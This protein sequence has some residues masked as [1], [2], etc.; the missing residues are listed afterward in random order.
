MIQYTCYPCP[1]GIIKIGWENDRV[2]SIRCTDEV[3]ACNTSSPVSDLAA[4]QLA[5]YFAGKRSSFTFPIDP[6]GTAFQQ[7][8]WNALGRIPYGKVVTYKEIA[9]AIGNPSAA[10][11]VGM[12]CNR[13]P[14]WIAIPCHR[15]IGS[16]RKLTGYAGG[17]DMKQQLLQLE[18]ANSPE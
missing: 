12:A 18:Q 7:S 1:I 6:K 8:V 9:A 14:I 13:N 3:D 11:A 15:V 4:V 16:N 17:M 2:I 10:R 5:E